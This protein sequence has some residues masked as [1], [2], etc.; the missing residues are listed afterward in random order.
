LH[1]ILQC[2]QTNITCSS[3]HLGVHS[4]CEALA[5]GRENERPFPAQKRH[6]HGNQ[7]KDCTDDSWGIDD[8]VLL[9][10]GRGT[11]LA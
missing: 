1:D 8:N 7:G 9:A 5:N 11:K 4:H 6:L 10:I 3:I 2:I